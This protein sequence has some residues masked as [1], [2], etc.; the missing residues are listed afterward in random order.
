MTHQDA[1]ALL[2]LG[3]GAT[4]EDVKDAHRRAVLAVHPDRIDRV[5]NPKAWE[6][7]NAM[8]RRLNEAAEV[9][10]AA[11]AAAVNDDLDELWPEAA[12]IVVDAGQGSVS[13]LQRRLGLGYTRASRIVDQL[14]DARI[15]GPF[16]GSATRAALVSPDQL[17]GLLQSRGFEPRPKAPGTSPPPPKVRPTEADY[18]REVFWISVGGFLLVIVLPWMLYQCAP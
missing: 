16:E 6:A 9:L 4:S 18:D 17:L 3:P 5:G 8:L 10:Q 13:L 7:S 2:D 11:P 15:V 12:Q 14:E 1:R